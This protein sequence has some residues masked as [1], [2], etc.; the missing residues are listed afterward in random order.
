MLLEQEY[1]YKV[2]PTR[3]LARKI[4]QLTIRSGRARRLLFGGDV[5]YTLAVQYRLLTIK[6]YADL[7][8][9]AERAMRSLVML[10]QPRHVTDT[11]FDECWPNLGK[12]K[13]QDRIC[14]VPLFLTTGSRIGPSEL[15]SSAGTNSD[16]IGSRP[17][18]PGLVHFFSGGMVIGEHL[19]CSK[20]S[21]QSKISP[22]T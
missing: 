7:Q 2:Q 13:L 9:R 19:Q 3:P 21:T 12:I 10:T 14:L 11:N 16:Q 15:S 22:V 4:L 18:E 1:Q 20:M 17:A 6:S 8:Q 5:N